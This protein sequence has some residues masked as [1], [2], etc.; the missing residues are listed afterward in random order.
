MSAIS[1]I[2]GGTWTAQAMP[3]M[4]AMRKRMFATVDTDGSG[5]VDATELQKVLDKVSERSG[6]DVG[7]ASDLMTQ[8]D[9]DGNGNL[10]SD[11][12]DTGMKSLMP[13]PSST[14]EFA[15]MRGGHGKEDMFAKVD[16]DGSGS[17]DA[18]ELQ[19]MIDKISERSGK[20]IGKASDL[21]TQWDGDGNGSLSSEELDKGVKSTL[22]PP[23]S[24]VD[25]AQMR[26]GQGMDGMQMGGMPPPAG[27]ADESSGSS[28]SSG[29]SS[30][31]STDPADTNGDGVVSAGER[32]AADLKRL[33]ESLTAAI[34]TN[35]DKS[36]GSDELS[37]F[38][39]R[40]QQS[41]DTTA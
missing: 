13:A 27:G 3:D 25:F 38:L 41:I 11:E 4:S 18:T 9:S 31:D 15:Q 34:D 10:S 29:S 21:L 32:A 26:G 16:A 40:L 5:G 2:G 33:V 17:V 37:S 1:G 12:L 36:L 35:G 6:K 20:D 39:T 22:Q 14:V 19:Q 7:K 23:S 28:T 8:W 30:S 24:T